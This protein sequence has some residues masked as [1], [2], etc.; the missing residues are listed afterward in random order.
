MVEALSKAF[1]VALDPSEKAGF[2]LALSEK[3]LEKKRARAEALIQVHL[4]YHE[5]YRA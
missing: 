3:Y 2:H 4:V 1:N 5:A